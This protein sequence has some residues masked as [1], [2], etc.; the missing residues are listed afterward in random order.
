MKRKTNLTLLI[1]FLHIIFANTMSAQI[2][3]NLPVGTIPGAIDVSPMGAATY[4]IPIE[5]V[6][7]T[8]GVQPNLSIVYN[9][10][11]G[12]G[13]LGMK[14]NLA[15]LSVISRCG[16]TNYYDGNVTAIK[17]NGNDRFALDG[18]RLLS[19]NGNYGNDGTEYATEVEDF[20]RIVSYG[21]G[22]T[23]VPEYFK[24][25]TGNGIVVEYGY[26][27]LA[28][29]KLG[30]GNNSILCWYIDKIT[31]DN[32]N[33]MT[34]HYNQ[35]NDKEIWIDSIKYTG[36]NFQ[37][38]AKVSFE[39]TT[40]TLNPNTYFVGGYGITQTKLIEYITVFYGNSTVRKYKFNY[41]LNILGERTA[42]LKEIVLF[43]ENGEQYLNATTLEW[44]AQNT[45]IEIPEVNGL[46]I[47]QSLAGQIL[48]GDF[49][50]DGYTDVLLY[51]VGSNKDTWKLYLYSPNSK[52]FIYNTQGSHQEL[53]TDNGFQQTFFYSYGS[54][55]QN[56]LVV[57]KAPHYQNVW[58]LRTLSFNPFST[59]V[60]N[61]ITD[62]K[63]VIFGKF[64]SEDNTNMLFLCSRDD[65]EY[66][67][68]YSPNQ[69]TG[70][71]FST[72]K[73]DDPYEIN[74]GDING[75]GRD[76]IQVVVNLTT[77][78]YD[79][80][81]G[82]L[83]TDGFPTAYHKVYFGDFNGDGIQD[84][85]AY[86]NNSNSK[87]W[88]LHLGKGENLFTHPGQVV[89]DL[90][91][92]PLVNKGISKPKYPVIVADINGDGK[93][94]IIQAYNWIESGIWKTRL[95]FY[96]VDN[97]IPDGSCSLVLITQQVIDEQFEYISKFHLGD[98]NNDGK[99]DILMRSSI[100]KN[101]RIVYA[102]KN[103]QY[104]FVEQIT[105]GLVN[106]T[107]L[108][109]KSG[110][111]FAESLF[112]PPSN[113]TPISKLRKFF[114]TPIDSIQISNGITDN[115]NTIKYA[116]ELPA[117]S[118]RRN[119]FLGFRSFSSYNVQ[120]MTKE[121]IEHKIDNSIS[122]KGNRE[123][124]VP[125]STSSFVNS[126]LISN[127]IYSNQ[128][129]N[130][131]YYH[132]VHYFDKVIVKNSISNTKTETSSTI[133]PA[134]RLQNTNTKTYND[135][136]TNIWLHSETQ[137]YTY[138]TI[139][140]NGNQKKTVPTQVLTT[141]QYGA[142]GVI[143][144]DTVTNEYYPASEKGR[145]KWQ[146]RGNI[147][148]SITTSYEYLNPTGVCTLKTVSAAG[149][150][151][152]TEKYEYDATRRFVTKITNPLNHDATFTYDVKTGNKLSETNANLLT[153]NYIYDSFG[154]L[155]QIN[156][157]DG[158]ITEDIIY[159][160]SGSI[161][162][163]A[164]YCTKTTT[165]GQ[166]ELIVYYDILGREVCRFDD[167][168]YY[169]TR[170]NNKGQVTQTSY[171]YT[172]LTEPDNS[173]I[174]SEY[175][176]DSFGRKNKEIAPYC[177]LSY[178]YNNR[179]VTVTDHLRSISTWKDCD[180]LGRVTQA[181]D[182][183]GTITYSYSVI[184]SGNK[185]R[186]QTQITTNGAT[187]TIETDL[188]G[189]RLKITEPNAGTIKST[190]NKFNELV[191]QTD[192]RNITTTYE[193]DKLG[194]VTQKKID[195]NVLIIKDP[196][197]RETDIMR[198]GSQVITTTYTYDNFSSN[199]KGKGKI[200]QISVD[201]VV[202]ET[203]IYDNKGSLAQHTKTI[204][205]T[206]YTFNYTYTSTGQ[207]ETLT[208]PDNYAVK[209]SYSATGKMT[210]IRNPA[211]NSLI[212]KV[213]SR[214]KF[215]ATTQCEYG[216]G[217][218]AE[219]TFNDFG[220]LTRINTGNKFFL[221]EREG[222]RGP[223]L[224]RPDSSILNYRYAYDTKGLI[225]SRSE[226]ILNRL[227][228]FTYDNLD[229]LTK[230]TAG[231]IGQTGVAQNF[232]FHNNGNIT[233]NSQLG[234][235]FYLSSKPHAVTQIDPI[236][237][238]VIS[239]AQCNITYNLFNQ[240]IQI[241]EPS[242][243]IS[244]RFDLF[245]GSNQQR[246]KMVQYNRNFETNVCYYIN[247]YYEVEVSGTRPKTTSNYHYIYGENGIVALQIKNVTLN[248]DSIY[249]IHTDHLGSY[250]AITNSA[251]QVRQRN[252]FDPWGNNIGAVNY[253]LTTRGFTGHEHYPELKIINMNGRLYDPVI[254][255]FFSPD[256]YV[257]NSS[258]TQDFNR[259][260]YARNCPLMYTDPSG[261]FINYIIGAIAGGLMNWALNG[262]EF[263]WKGLAY[264]GIGAA[265]GALGAGIGGGISS[266]IA[267][268]GFSAGFLGTS[269]AGVAASSF[270]NGFAVGFGAG[271]SSSFVTG[272]GNSWM[273]GAGFGKGLLNG[274]I[275]GAMSGLGSGLLGG[276][277]G[278]F[279]AKLDGR[280]FMDGATIV[281]SGS[282]GQP[283]PPIS[284]GQ[285][286]CL[287]DA[288]QAIDKSLELNHSP[289]ELFECMV[290][291]N[292]GL[293]YAD[294][295]LQNYAEWTGQ[296]F[297]DFSG[298]PEGAIEAF[299]NGGRTTIVYSNDDGSSHAV[300]L[301]KA[302]ARTITKINGFKYFI[303]T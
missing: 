247:K 275:S 223:I 246:N 65:K 70:I 301:Y 160:H 197:P 210:E 183:G 141:Q 196:P 79:L 136:N 286:R 94:E 139:T 259:Y 127:T 2:N 290:L 280:R 217:V 12:M 235:Y 100:F 71:T 4:T 277:V 198:A 105:D 289:E 41:N 191:K 47:G 211:N 75:I 291:G 113:T 228:T 295:T 131:A 49:D 132:Y 51:G 72:N 181:Q 288:L 80:E 242:G 273:G 13:L 33:Y 53:L 98:F 179:K 256:K 133:C 270:F 272:A 143:I 214:N 243:L 166:P 19:V 50:G 189:N 69:T 244:Y 292:N 287:Y 234:S 145:L 116:F 252:F 239:A 138:Q 103:E 278:G 193:Y 171:P 157:P 169:D 73:K 248:T 129:Q 108:Y 21:G 271:F 140:L 199:N 294:V 7:G 180:A 163:N 241:T 201:N 123:I 240:P 220:L 22:T 107:K 153:T 187:T 149:C 78:T 124:L 215:N 258:F 251:K 172:K 204:D 91:N 279:D 260:S 219:Y 285:D 57:E 44:G 226:R 128:F 77:K 61:Y 255:R 96:Y 8:Q 264:F 118:F 237:E 200:H 206:P 20:T 66:E 173:K 293:P 59:H 299:A 35:S 74:V 151:P 82:L 109:Y 165:T 25:F 249:Y 276:I 89:S 144:T 253:S 207:L 14:W 115:L 122:I 227:E 297:V 114:L 101:P 178:S 162:S 164:K 39:Y 121:T 30:S 202:D 26:T 135:C 238:N 213:V 188:W 148:G 97:L 17:F 84:I 192:A 269:A 110:Y 37:P 119:I 257:A 15:G 38:Y 83:K 104:D 99:V 186:H 263:T 16:Q 125:A 302:Q 152:R 31:D 63:S 208:Y 58:N 154:R 195:N 232:Y 233:A 42:H 93:D 29:Q 184:T 106:K 185:P 274:V 158:N 168:N 218:V 203:Y 250:C 18:A 303:Q 281:K 90:D 170:Y 120:L 267:G 36:N 60:M 266:A 177:S 190:Y 43:S 262:C 23:G 265:A 137:T 236:N 1:L 34:F 174:W 261:E 27:T 155:K 268:T 9:S 48:T 88:R 254:A 161:P 11:G 194:R 224:Y 225:S 87:E 126:Q 6:P 142:T 222:L 212:Y 209:Y 112:Y 231:Q 229:R 117:F 10:Y 245:Y 76:V 68:Y 146:R 134:G 62:F 283:I 175:F 5:V 86:C 176:Y 216:N 205:N 64:D 284:T 81:K 52:S 156:H 46:P 300:V 221:E 55:K 28:K 159:W 24:A 56:V 102:N 296:T 95:K 298:N 167:G 54:L 32:G 147:D 282:F 67:F 45:I 230:I 3:T 150:A 182:P 92:T 111:Y 85:L 40:N 130:I